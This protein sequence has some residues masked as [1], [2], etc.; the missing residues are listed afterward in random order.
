[1]LSNVNIMYAVYI[2]KYNKITLQSAFSNSNKHIWTILTID[3]RVWPRKILGISK[4]ISINS[5]LSF[6]RDRSR[7]MQ[8]YTDGASRRVPYKYQVDGQKIGAV[9]VATRLFMMVAHNTSKQSTSID[10]I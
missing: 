6:K 2:I 10:G 7:I 8:S 3:W 9:W 1:M 4:N 5:G